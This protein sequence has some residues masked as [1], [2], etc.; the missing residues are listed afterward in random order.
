[1]IYLFLIKMKKDMQLQT[2]LR[3]LSKTKPPSRSS[4]TSY[5]HYE[6]VADIVNFIYHSGFRPGKELYVLKHE[7]FHSIN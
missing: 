2:E 5:K 4:L 1:M 3:R 7:T 6:E